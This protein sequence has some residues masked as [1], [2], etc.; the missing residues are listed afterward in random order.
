DNFA[1]AVMNDVKVE[2]PLESIKWAVKSI[3][4]L[5]VHVG[6]IMGTSFIK[7]KNDDEFSSENME[8]MLRHSVRAHLQYLE[9]NP[10]LK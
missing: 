5:V 1:T 7:N 9:G 10:K 4:S 8:N 6:V 3:F 2:L